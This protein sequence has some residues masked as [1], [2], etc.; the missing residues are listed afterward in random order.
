[1]NSGHSK[2]IKLKIK[3]ILDVGVGTL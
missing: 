3:K 2:K 1:M